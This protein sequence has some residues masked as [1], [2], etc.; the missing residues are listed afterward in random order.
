MLLTP[1]EKLLE[2]IKKFSKATE[3]KINTQKSVVFL[4]ISNKQSENKIKKTISFTL[5]SK[6]VKY[7]GINLN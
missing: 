5:A 1:P 3:Y 2:L 7:L 4:H 6:R